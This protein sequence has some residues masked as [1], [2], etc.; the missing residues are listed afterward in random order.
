[1]ATRIEAK[2]PDV[3]PRTPRAAPPCAFVIFGAS[4][5]LTRRKLVPAL[6]QLARRN[7]LPD[8]FALQTSWE[9]LLRRYVTNPDAFHCPGDSERD[10]PGAAWL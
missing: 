10:S 3:L 5:D 6:Y 8:P 4:G 2:V 7:L 1:M 9:Q